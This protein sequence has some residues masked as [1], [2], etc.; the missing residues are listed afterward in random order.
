MSKINSTCQPCS[1]FLEDFELSLGKKMPSLHLPTK[2][3]TCDKAKWSHHNSFFV[4]RQVAAAKPYEQFNM[5]TFSPKTFRC[6]L[7]S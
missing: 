3:Y 6:L 4:F 1:M 2:H 5:R 7:E